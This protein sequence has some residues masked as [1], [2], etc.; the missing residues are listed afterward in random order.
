MIPQ[1]E[2]ISWREKAPW[3][4]DA[5]VEQDLVL[6][7][8]LVEI[9]SEDALRDQLAF[10]GGTAL[11]KLV[12]PV[13]SRY[14]EDI[15]LVQIK[16]SPIGAAL[17]LLRKRLDPWLGEPKREFNEGRVTLIYRFSSEIPPV[18]NLRLKIEINTREHFTVLGHKTHKFS[19]KSRWF[20]GDAEIF[21]YPLEEM[22]GTKLRALYQR[23]KGRDIFDIAVSVKHFPKLSKESVVKCF[24]KYMAHGGHKVSRAE[25]EKNL[26][27]KAQ[28]PAFLKDI[29]PLLSAEG[30][31]EFRLETALDLMRND[32]LPLLPGEPW[33]RPDTKD[34]KKK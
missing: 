33:V 7:R 3:S 20:S 16:A 15:D 17:N 21:S 8:A 1:A 2:V 9:F 18:T 23:K 31:S 29:E 10:R 14:S 22:L 24:L 5:Q 30:R 4:T 6:S 19:V 12:L 34:G 27:E 32:F 26:A 25:Y 13:P 28:H 11:N